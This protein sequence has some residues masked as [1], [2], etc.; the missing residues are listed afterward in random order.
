[1]LAVA[2]GGLLVNA[3]GLL[4]LRTDHDANLNMRG[5]RLHVLTD[6]LGSLQAIIAG[7]L[8][9]TYGWY[10]VDPVASVLIG[11]LVIYSS[12]SLIKQSVAVLMEGAPGHINVDDVRNALLEL[13]HVV[14]VHDLHVWTITSG[15]VALSAH[16]TCPGDHKHDSLL[17]AARAML[18]QRFGIR[19]TTIQIDSDL[20]CEGADHPPFTS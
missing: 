10:W 4:I 18:A 13:P 17:F 1:M 11:L 5:A 19:H 2:S 8:I 12:W 6:A 14:N 16:V 15:F 7:A 20:S 3:A 9:W